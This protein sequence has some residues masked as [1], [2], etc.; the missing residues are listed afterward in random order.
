MR[1]AVH[2]PVS[3]PNSCM[4]VKGGYAPLLPL[5]GR[6]CPPSSGSAVISPTTPRSLPGLL[7]AFLGGFGDS[8]A[9]ERS[10]ERLGRFLRAG[11][12]ERAQRS[13]A[14]LPLVYVT[15]FGRS[16]G[17]GWFQATKKPGLA[18]TKTGRNLAGKEAP[19]REKEDTTRG[20]CSL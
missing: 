10:S 12:L 16:P 17:G 18:V 15:I 2:V 6:G 19:Y 1:V 20:V 7:G 13:A 9:Y 3:L 5:R 14:Q 4:G 11:G 8:T